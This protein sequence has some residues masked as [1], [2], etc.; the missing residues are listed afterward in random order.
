[1]AGMV[2]F[3]LAGVVFFGIA[4]AMTAALVSIWFAAGALAALLAAFL[5]AGIPVQIA[6]FLVVSALTLALTRPLVKK[7]QSDKVVPTN[8]DRI[9]G[10]TARVTEAIDNIAMTGAVYT[11]GK[12]WTARSSTG[13]PIPADSTVTVERI[14]GVKLFV[15]PIEESEESV[16]NTSSFPS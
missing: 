8:A 15:K 9:V 13:S 6:V 5:G 16:C 1:M 4:E 11:D 3:W 7:Y 14:D 2:W 10:T 12:S